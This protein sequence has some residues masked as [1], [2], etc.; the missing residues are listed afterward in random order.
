MAALRR[1][2]LAAVVPR[3]QLDG[4]KAVLARLLDGVEQLWKLRC[5]RER[6]S[7]CSKKRSACSGSPSRS[8][9]T[10]MRLSACVSGCS[11]W[12]LRARSNAALALCSAWS[13]SPS[14]LYDTANRHKASH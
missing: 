8:W 12:R 5:S 3:A 11:S 7:A 10:P 4:A 1:A 2:Q 9:Q 13:C 6:A 14:S